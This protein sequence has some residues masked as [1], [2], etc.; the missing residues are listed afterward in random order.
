MGYGL[1]GPEL[2]LGGARF[3]FSCPQHQNLASYPKDIGGPFSL[4]LSL[5]TL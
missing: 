4:S 2:I 1:E 5:S 3:F